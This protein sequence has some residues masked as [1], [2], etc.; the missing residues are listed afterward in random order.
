MKNRLSILFYV[1]LAMTGSLAVNG[2]QASAATTERVSIASGG[3]QGNGSSEGSA[4]SADGRYVAFTS[5]AS[6]LVTGDTYG[7][8][9]VFVH[10]RE[11]NVTERVSMA[12]NG[13]QANDHAWHIPAI[14]ADGRYVAFT[15]AASNLVS[16]DTNGSWD[17]FVHDRETNVTELVS[18]ASDGTLGDFVSE[19]P[20]IS[21]D[22][23]Y[24]VFISGATNL[25]PNDTNGTF[26]IFVHDRTTKVTERVSISSSGV[27]GNDVSYTYT[28]SPGI[29]DDGRYV[30]F[31]SKAS[32]LVDGDTNGARDIF[33]HDRQTKVTERVSIAS[34]VTQ[35]DNDSYDP[36]ISADGRY[37]AFTSDASNLAPDSAGG[38]IFIH[39]RDAK[40]T[41][42]VSGDGLFVAISADG[43]YVAFKSTSASPY[44]IFVHDSQTDVTDRVS[45]AGDGTQGNGSSNH[46]SI[47][48]DGRYVAF[49][50]SATNL[51]SGDTNGVSDVFVLERTVDLGIIKQAPV[52][53]N[54]GGVFDYVLS[55]T[56]NDSIT[57]TGVTITDALPQTV[58]FLSASSGCSESGGT[59]TCSLG[60][61]PKG[62]TSQATITVRAGAAEVITNTASVSAEQTD[63]NTANNSSGA[64]TSAANAPALNDQTF[65]MAENS[66]N[67]AVVGTVAA[68][69]PDGD[70][71]TFSVT[72]GSPNPFT[73]NSATGQLT[74]ADNSQL[75]Y[76]TTPQFLL[77]VQATDSS[78][79]SDSGI[80]TI[81]VANLNE[82][83][84]AL[85]LG[86]TV[87]D[88]NTNTG[89][90]YG[91]GTLSTIDPDTGDTFIYAIAGGADAALFSIS[92]NQLVLTAGVLDY[93]TKSSYSIT[94][95]STDSGGLSIDRSFTI[96]V[97]DLND[98]PT[99]ANNTVS[100]N[101]DTAYSFTTANFGFMDQ[102]AGN[103]LQKVQITELPLQGSLALSGAAV[104][105]NQEISADD[106]ALSKLTFT[107]TSNTSGEPY[108]TFQFKVHDG[109]DYSVSAYTMTVNV[110]NTS[111]CDAATCEPVTPIPGV[112]VTFTGGVTAG[113]QTTVDI[114]TP[115]INTGTCDGAANFDFGLNILSQSCYDIH[116]DAVFNGTVNI[117][118]TYDDTNLSL[119]QEQALTI[120]HMESGSWQ[121]RTT[122]VNTDTNIVCGEV[123]GFSW[124]VIGYDK[125]PPTFTLDRLRD[126]LWPPDHKMV[127]VARVTNVADSADPSPTVDIRVSSTDVFIGKDK[128][129]DGKDKHKQKGEKDGKNGH[130]HEDEEDDD[131]EHGDNRHASD[132]KVRKSGDTWE[133]WV[134]AERS[135]KSADRIYTITA[136]VTDKGGNQATDSHTV[137]VPHDKNKK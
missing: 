23:R 41:K 93:E 85:S 133:V 79:L 77:V 75:D 61:V 92:G 14:S 59:V 29:S 31:R 131:A 44:D 57:A 47:S 7:A 112:E 2:D 24:V 17:V 11:N 10:D 53:V 100:I 71:L 49:S 58:S 56:N 21:A 51:V 89:G 3:A 19:Y 110:L 91:I 80:V 55:V 135:G 136:T 128:D 6:N 1:F 102:D 127:K 9:D 65:S 15:S 76:E 5:S 70:T 73:I 113:G 26:D 134:R 124:F 82:S 109:T 105:L 50:S 87:V 114:Y 117:C 20:R 66:A 111:A 27:E 67:G 107:P 37:V 125:T 78:G 18:K 46:P 120:Q 25:V 52:T 103:T 38:G 69:D 119:E 74:V 106:I 81:N 45:T 64:S 54:T 104:T 96:T 97:T 33:V 108:T 129:K 62:T 123:S 115:D 39:D 90:G 86:N 68:S 132:W 122:S 94:V 42:R 60:T 84:T 99:A 34:D 12:S 35:G 16:G 8:T 95:R 98:A 48:A 130:K 126:T 43:R 72:S 28:V 4:I 101:E 116:T 36:V 40:T 118:L 30:A 121:N 22:G 83:P 63:P 88:E 32:N 137:L 13:T